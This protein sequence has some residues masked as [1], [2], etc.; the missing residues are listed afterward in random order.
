MQKAELLKKSG[1]SDDVEQKYLEKLWELLK[2]QVSKYNGVDS[3]SIQ[4]EKAQELL[5]SAM[6]T[7]SLC[8][9]KEGLSKEELLS[10]DLEEVLKR[11]QR[12]LE[13]K[14]EEAYARWEAFSLEAP[15]IDNVYYVSTIKELGAFFERYELYYAAHEIPCSIEYPLLYPISDDVKGISFIEEYLKRLKLEC[16]IIGSFAPDGVLSLLSEVCDNYK[17][18]YMNLCEPVLVRGFGRIL[19][20]RNL[21]ELSLTKDD[22]ASLS[23]FF[24]EKT[25]DEIRDCLSNGVRTFLKTQG[26]S[27]ALSSY[28]GKEIESLSKRTAIS[29]GEEAV[30]AIFLIYTDNKLR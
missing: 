3:T 18:E 8:A 29:R 10:L 19:L 23:R 2:K 27:E 15:K 16:R 13:K 22:A 30:P 12:I 9:E 6:Y 14:K 17:E 4:I 5:A 1:A 26:F 25:E 21:G 24:S 20:G 7:V 11:G 28:F